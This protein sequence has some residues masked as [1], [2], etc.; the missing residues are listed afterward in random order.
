MAA[1]AS[2]TRCGRRAP[3]A[4]QCSGQWT[5]ALCQHPNPCFGSNRCLNGGTCVTVAAPAGASHSFPSFKCLCRLGYSASLCEIQLPSVCDRNPCLNDGKCQLK[6]SLQDF[7]CVCADGWTG[8]LCA[9]EDHCA[10]NQCKNGAKCVSKG[11][12][13]DCE[14][15]KGFSGRHCTQDVDECAAEDM[16]SGNGFCLNTFGH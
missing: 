5:G 14:C 6:N 9:L 1:N 7:Q 16:C 13:Y 3:S 15:A 2:K 4:G 10:Q 8:R 12:G 11:R